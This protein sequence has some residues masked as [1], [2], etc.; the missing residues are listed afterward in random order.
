MI[1]NLTI[2]A[3][4][5]I[6]AGCAAQSNIYHS[7]DAG[8]PPASPTVLLLPPEVTVSLLTSGG[9]LKPRADW[10]ETVADSLQESLHEYFWEAGQEFQQFEA[11]TA[12]DRHHLM[13]KQLNTQ[14][15]A[16][17]L[18]I[19]KGGATTSGLGGSRSHA[20]GLN[21][22]DHLR[23]H[24][25]DYALIVMLSAGRGSS[26]RIITS[27]FA[28]LAGVSVDT[29]RLEF[30][31]ALIDLRTGHIKWANFDPNALSEMGDLLNASPKRWNKAVSH[32]LT[33]L[34][35]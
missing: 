19:L 9:M 7:P 15:D 6:L 3:L 34:P 29:A 8:E 2:L 13:A 21:D 25:T 24:D 33:D 12:T 5:A 20:L 32:L 14:L 35:L 30:R 22:I 1:R 10:S 4:A 28:G 11:G 27:M 17:E 26:G 23:R 31:A 16:I 18:A